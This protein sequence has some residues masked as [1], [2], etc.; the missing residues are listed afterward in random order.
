MAAV[1]LWQEDNGLNRFHCSCSEVRALG[2]CFTCIHIHYLKA[3][4]FL[5]ELMGESCMGL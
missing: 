3:E 4:D 5:F 1:E 2:Q